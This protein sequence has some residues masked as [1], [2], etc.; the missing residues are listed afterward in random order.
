[1]SATEN[2][3]KL[4]LKLPP[5][6]APIGV[7]VPLKRSGN[8]AFTSGM[9]P[10]GADGKLIFEGKLGANVDVAAAEECAKLCVLNALAHIVAQL[11][12]LDRVKSVVKVVGF[13][14]SAVGFNKQGAVMNAASQLLVDIFGVE[15]GS[16]ARSAVGVAELPAGAPVEVE[17]IV[18]VIG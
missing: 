4:G 11:G 7:Y 5:P 6:P 14:A 9:L 3:A 13:V 10:V 1:M 8:M 18:E 17:L 2:L 15:A 16:H 12:S